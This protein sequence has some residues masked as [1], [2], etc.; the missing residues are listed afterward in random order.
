TT[1]TRTK[2]ASAVGVTTLP[3]FDAAPL[4][5][6]DGGGIRGS[7]SRHRIGAAR[8]RPTDASRARQAQQDRKGPPHPSHVNAD[9][10]FRPR[11]AHA[12]RSPNGFESEFASEVVAHHPRE[13]AQVADEIRARRPEFRDAAVQRAPEERIV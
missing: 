9:R 8:G 13:P 12:S 5:R 7:R 11:S 2:Y 1:Q 3:D 4:E 10:S 6:L